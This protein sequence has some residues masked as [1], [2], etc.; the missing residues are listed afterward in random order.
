MEEKLRLDC[1]W[2]GQFNYVPREVTPLGYTTAF[3]CRDCRKVT[4]Y[5]WTVNSSQVDTP[6]FKTW[7]K[8]AKEQD[9]YNPKIVRGISASGKDVL[10]DD[11]Y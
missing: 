10:L 3:R 11:V 9:L 6:E 7:V 8:R 4:Q 5:Y 2:C 1:C